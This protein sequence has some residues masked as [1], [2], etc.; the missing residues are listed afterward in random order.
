M[1]DK[2]VVK[3]EVIVDEEGRAKA[4]F[5][6]L[7]RSAE[8][9]AAGAESTGARAFQRLR[10]EHGRFVSATQAGAQTLSATAKAYE[11]DLLKAGVAAERAREEALKFQQTSAGAAGEAARAYTYTEKEVERLRVSLRETREEA[12]AL[13][14]ELARQG[15]APASRAAAELARRTERGAAGLDAASA[16]RD[17]SGVERVDAFS[18]GGAQRSLAT[19]REEARGFN[20]EVE[21][22]GNLLTSLNRRL[23]GLGSPIGSVVRGL[24]GG[25]LIVEA[26]RAAVDLVEKY[27]E[28]KRADEDARRQLIQSSVDA[29][30]NIGREIEQVNA[31]AETYHGLS[32]A[33]LSSIQAQAQRA[34]HAPVTQQAVEEEKK[35]ADNEAT[36]QLRGLPD[37]AISRAAL[38]AAIKRGLSDKETLAQDGFVSRLLGRNVRAEATAEAARKGLAE[39]VAGNPQALTGLSDAEAQAR[40]AGVI[41]KL[42]SEFTEEEKR[43]ARINALLNEQGAAYTTAADAAATYNK[44]LGDSNRPKPARDT[45]ELDLSSA[46]AAAVSLFTAYR[47]NQDE[48]LKESAE[49]LKQTQADSR[50]AADQEAADSLR[51]LEIDKKYKETSKKNQ[52]EFW[53]DVAEIDRRN[54]REAEERLRAYEQMR[55]AL[56]SARDAARDFLSGAAQAQDRDNPLIGLFFR[57]R[58]EVEE[59]RKRFMTFG[60][61]FADM[62]ARIK[63]AEIEQEVAAARLQSRLSG[64]RAEQEARRLELPQTDLTG[65]EE[66]RLAVTQARAAAAVNAPQL[67]AEAAALQSGRALDPQS[68][69]AILAREAELRTQLRLL[70]DQ[71]SP[72]ANQAKR[73]ELQKQLEAQELLLRQPGVDFRSMQTLF[74]QLQRLEGLRAAGGGRLGD[75][76]R[77]LLN[78]QV[79]TLTGQIDPRVLATDPRFGGVRDLRARSLVEQAQKFERDVRDARQREEVGDRIQQDARELVR[80]IKGAPGVPG[81]AK[82]KELLAVTGSLSD[83]ELTPDLR[84]ARVEALRAEAAAD[85]GR[86]ARADKIA[87][88]LVGDNGLLAK[89]NK[90]ITDK[91]FKLDGAAFG[92][93]L[94]VADGL[95]VDKSLV[96]E[97]PTAGPANDDGY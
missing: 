59:T 47:K 27:R 73:E 83:K 95:T 52:E 76:T 20:E 93:N 23:P 92:I 78:Q 3:V 25:L 62:M 32:K 96:G 64:L 48:L 41:D 46:G 10:D 81:A 50:A 87:E 33:I 44:T 71:G 55:S 90:A 42:P 97:T 18:R 8:Q 61:D 54:E 86:E 85:A 75:A 72:A 45:T 34:R 67:L 12:L 70:P 17:Q 94:N 39:L 91:G 57:L 43:L 68:L 40:F 19:L 66:R 37:E 35:N 2:N 88:A 24:F 63:R 5:D 82:L 4:G 79:L 31:L 7:T 22:S 77:D 89:L 36:R 80:T 14:K 38:D 15:N 6:D 65:P 26:V 21:K 51:K 69:N 11:Q 58:T 56:I 28:L 1:G 29:G 74:E 53:K 13:Q 49:A 30:A 60:S 16:G 84:Q 9:F